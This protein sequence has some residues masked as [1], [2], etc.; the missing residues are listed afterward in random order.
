[1]FIICVIDLSTENKIKGGGS[2]FYKNQK[3][4]RLEIAKKNLFNFISEIPYYPHMGFFRKCSKFRRNIPLKFIF[5]TSITR[6]YSLCKPKR[7]L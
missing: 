5:H 6:F 2:Y 4:R 7:A 3:Y 1:M